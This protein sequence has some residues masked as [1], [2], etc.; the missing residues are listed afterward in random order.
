MAGRFLRLDRYGFVIYNENIGGALMKIIDDESKKLHWWN[1]N[2]FFAGTVFVVLLNII[3][4]A[5]DPQHSWFYNWQ[6]WKNGAPLSCSNLAKLFVGSFLHLNW[7]HCLLNMLCFLICGAWL[8]RRKGTLPLLGLVFVLAWIS[9][10][11]L[12]GNK[13]TTSGV[14][15]SGVNYAFYAYAIIDYCFLFLRKSTRTKFNIIS[16]AVLIALIYFAACFAGGTRSVTFQWYPY[17]FMNNIAHYSGFLGGAILAVTIQLVKLIAVKQH[18]EP[19][20]P[21]PQQVTADEAEQKEPE[22]Q[23]ETN[24]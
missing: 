5:A 11:F 15:Y 23:P 14:G 24:E 6:A 12:G 17:D 8:E 4:Y 10:A 13:L 16:G 9:A 21:I 18:K 22:E 19:E 20:K 2:Y 1:R 7:Q 3:I